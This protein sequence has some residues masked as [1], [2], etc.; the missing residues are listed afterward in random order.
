MKILITG[1][2][3]F[4]GGFLARKLINC[5][6]EVVGI[7]INPLE[8][9]ENLCRSI[10]GDVVN[11]KDIMR[12]AQGVDVI[13]HLAAKHHDFG[14]SREDFFRVNV[15]GTSNILDCAAQLGINKFIF[16]S[17]PAVYGNPKAYTTEDTVPH[18]ISDYGE[19]KLAAEKL[20]YGWIAKNPKR[21]AVILR[22]TVVF[23]PRNYANMYSLIDSIYK[24]RFL[25]VGKGKNIK[26]IAYVE[27]LVDAT[28]FL[29]EKLNPWVKIYNYS[30]YPQ[31]TSAQIVETIA[32]C[33]GC[34]IPKFKVPLRPAILAASVFDILA[35]VTGYN[36][37][38]TAYRIRKF[39]TA[40]FHKSDKIRALGFQPKT[41]LSVGFKRMVE[42]YLED[43]NYKERP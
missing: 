30:D 9:K 28:V 38:I 5:G 15:K 35:K 27:N 39:N 29:L 23:G 17:T 11:P 36:F 34:G 25:F 16:Y 33:L 4:I 2:A 10:V 24:K 3:G 22:P 31:L 21:Q 26:S 19:S 13:I 41:D 6:Y 18:P 42:W 14:I 1:H 32:P 37:P 20:I 12:A 43:K 7:D 8:S 40:T